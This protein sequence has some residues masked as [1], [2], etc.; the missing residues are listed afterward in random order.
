MRIIFDIIDYPDLPLPLQNDLENVLGDPFGN[1]DVGSAWTSG[2]IVCSHTSDD[3]SSH[4]KE[5]E[6][7]G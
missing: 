4:K 1:V 7:S 2:G 6:L 5:D 3:N